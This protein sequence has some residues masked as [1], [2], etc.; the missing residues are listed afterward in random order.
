MTIDDQIEWLKGRYDELSKGNAQEQL[1]AMTVLELI[2]RLKARRDL[3][4]ATAFATSLAKR[5]AADAAEHMNRQILQT[6]NPQGP[7]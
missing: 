6:K 1:R 7:T 3:E 4:A 5:M 2:A